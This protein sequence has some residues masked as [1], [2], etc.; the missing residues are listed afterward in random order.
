MLDS[1]RDLLP[2][3][4]L[5]LARGVL[6]CNLCGGAIILDDDNRD[7]HFVFRSLLDMWELVGC[8]ERSLTDTCSCFSFDLVVFRRIPGTLLALRS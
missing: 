3:Q 1:V 4:K 2:E 5:C 8:I 7:F 6:V